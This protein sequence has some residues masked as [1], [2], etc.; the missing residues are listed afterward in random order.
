MRRGVL[1]LVESNARG[2]GVYLLGDV[3]PQGHPLYFLVAIATKVPLPLLILATT[4][5]TLLA[6]D[7]RRGSRGFSDLLWLAPALLYFGL[8]SLSSLQLGVR[9]ILPSLAFLALGCGRA[10]EL[11]L[12]RRRA[13]VAAA[14]LLAWL[15]VRT[16]W[17]YPNYIAHFNSLAGGADSGIRYLSDSNLDWGQ[18]LP[19]LAAY[20]Q[21]HPIG[22][23]RLAYFGSDNPDAHLPEDRF[24][25]IAP[26]WSEDLVAGLRIVPEPGY[27]AIS[28]TLLTGQLFEPRFRDYFQIFRD[29]KP[30]A[31]AGYSIFLYKVP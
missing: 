23:V 19:A 2:T 29:R 18:D 7:W 25:R 21:T 5:L 1:S 12:A 22:K 16:V 17:Q 15:C 20:L 9:L 26:P 3:Y 11:L 4:S 10:L 6:L 24:E 30:M 28:A 8:A 14:V 13:S 27:Y 31:K